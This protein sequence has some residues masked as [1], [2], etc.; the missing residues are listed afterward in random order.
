M[1][2]FQAIVLGGIYWISTTWFTYVGP[3]SLFTEP[4]TVSLWVGMVFH[5]VPTAMMIGATIQ[6]MYL[7]F[8]NAG[9][10]FATDKVAATIVTIAVIE[11]A[12]MSYDQGMALAVSVGVLTGQLHTIRRITAATWVNMADKYAETCNIRGIVLCG[13][14]YTNL[15][16]IVIFWIPMT[17]FLYLGGEFIGT[18]MNALPDAVK[19]GLTVVSKMMPALGYGMTVVVIGRKDLLPYFIGGFFFAKYS[20]LATMPIAMVAFFLAYLDMRFSASHDEGDGTSTG[21]LFDSLKGEDEEGAQRR[22]LTKRDVTRTFFRWVVVIEQSNSFERLQALAYCITIAPVLKKL[23]PNDQDGLREGLKRHL[24]FFNV[25]GIWGSLIHGIVLSME[26]QK[27]LGVDIPAAAITSV[28]TGLMGPISGIGDTIDWSTIKVLIMVM[29]LPYAAQGHW[30]AAL[31]MPVVLGVWCTME[32]L[33]FIHLG[34]RLGTGAATTLLQ[35]GALQKVLS[36]FG[37]VGMFMMGGLSAGMVNVN[38]GVTIPTSGEPMQLQADVLDKILPGLL[39]ILT[40][41]G[42]Y[43]YIAKGG[44]MLKCTL[45]ILLIGTVGGALGVFA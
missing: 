25:S 28:K 34:Y 40:V 26:E 24:V 22:L 32:G 18:A 19:N 35:S 45:W 2:L 11:T 12:G 10:T 41:L 39:S 36:F 27:A 16:K 5:D 14:V 15:S 30:W 9:G 42:V 6:P 44:T 43:R 7:A 17:V 37:V 29:A 4:I 3:N 20:G 38:I 23:Y 13:V 21:A 33:F 1:T 8:L 31:I